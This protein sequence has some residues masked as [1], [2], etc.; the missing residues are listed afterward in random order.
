M[1]DRMDERNMQ[2]Y[3]KVLLLTAHLFEYPDAV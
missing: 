3:Q 1:A 2:D